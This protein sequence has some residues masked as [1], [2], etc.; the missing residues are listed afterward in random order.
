MTNQ[1]GTFGKDYAQVTN[2]AAADTPIVIILNGGTYGIFAKATWGG[3]SADVQMLGPDG[4]T[5]ISVLAATFT[6][7]GF[8]TFTVPGGQC[9]IVFTTASACYASLSRINRGAGA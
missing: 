3:G 7:D 9:K 5:Y 2:A 8:K 6:A 1:L 4:V